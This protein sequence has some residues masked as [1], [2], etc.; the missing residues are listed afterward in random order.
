MDNRTLRELARSGIVKGLK[1]QTN[2]TLP[3]RLMTALSK[4]YQVK[5]LGTPT[6]FLGML[7]E[8]PAQHVVLLSQS[9][10]VS[11]MLYR[12]AMTTP[13][14]HQRPWYPTRAW[15]SMPTDGERRR[16]DHE[17]REVVG[18]LLYLARVTRPDIAFAVGQLSRHCAR[19]RKSAWDAAKFLLRYIGGTKDKRLCIEPASDEI[20]VASDADRK[21]I[22]GSRR[23]SVW[24]TSRVE[25]K[26]QSIVAESSTRQTSP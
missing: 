11:E 7:I 6:R 23:L 24:F 8:R 9:A 25:S 13:S 17:S 16:R 2:D 4:K 15:I 3:L 21:S 1:V 20:I 22:S 26:K 10:Y 19:P 5:D 12:F 18:A 14:R